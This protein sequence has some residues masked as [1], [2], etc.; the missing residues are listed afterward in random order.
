LKILCV[1]RKEPFTFGETGLEQAAAK[2]IDL[3][4]PTVVFLK[5]NLQTPALLLEVSLL[6]HCKVISFMQR[7]TV[8]KENAFLSSYSPLV[9]LLLLL[10]LFCWFLFF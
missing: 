4:T 7:E 2:T 9:V 1:C 6:S 8:I 10:L 5:V 3:F